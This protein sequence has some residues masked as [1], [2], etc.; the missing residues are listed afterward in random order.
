MKNRIRI[1]DIA[2]Q[3]GV[4][5]GTVDRVLHNRGE[6]NPE[7]REKILSLI[8]ETEYTPNLIAKSL[9]NRR[10]YHIAVLIPKGGVRNPYWDMPLAGVMRAA[11]ET[12]DNNTSIEVFL[13]D[14]DKESSFNAGLR[15][16]IESSPDGV[17]L[18][19]VFQKQSAEFVNQ[20]KVKGI[21]CVF[22]DSRVN[23]CA[24]L[25]AFGQD[26][27][28]S[29]YLAARLMCF[30]IHCDSTILILK[31]AHPN[32]II[33]HLAKREKGFTSYIDSCVNNINIR[34]IPLDIDI[35][36]PDEPAKSLDAALAKYLDT[37][38]IFVTNSRA[39]LVAEYLESLNYKGI[40]LIGYDLTEPNNK[41]LKKGFIDFLLSQ[42]PE[43]QG[44][45]CII[46]L[47]RYLVM[48]QTPGKINYSPIDII[49]KENI[50]YYH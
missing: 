12:Q 25:A 17:V 1:K 28:K 48:N 13:F 10:V 8:R 29:G 45:Q 47:Y 37:A 41:Y 9:A 19:P 33:R 11:G 40:I 21:P 38:G 44:Y 42:K 6:V 5:A 34:I 46:A 4:S 23:K 30:G 16:V 20:L 22:I 31:L 39:S 49:T 43:Y 36:A 32:G 3:A 2:L 24:A 7:T 27:V 26:T 50:A 14:L 18:S 35:T 15:E